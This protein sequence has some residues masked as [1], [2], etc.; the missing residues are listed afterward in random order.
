MGDEFDNLD[1][2]NDLAH[3]IYAFFIGVKHIGI[4]N[5]TSIH[6]KSENFVSFVFLFCHVRLSVI[7]PSMSLHSRHTMPDQAKL[8]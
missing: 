6:L 8:G 7:M 4:H 2:L 5:E 1:N 3:F